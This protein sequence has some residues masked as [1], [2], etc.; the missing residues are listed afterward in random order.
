[1]ELG[2]ALVVMVVLVEVQGEV[3]EQV[4]VRPGE[5]ALLSCG[6][7]WG[8]AG[9]SCTWR[10]P[11]NSTCTF[12][13]DGLT[14]CRAAGNV[15]LGDQATGLCQIRVANPT[16]G[17]NGVWGCS[18]GSVEGSVS[19]GE[20]ALWVAR[21]PEVE[22][23]DSAPGVTVLLVAGEAW[24]TGC[25]AI[26]TRPGGRLVFQ[27]A[28]ED[29]AGLASSDPVVTL[30]VDE[31]GPGILD[32][33]Q[34]L[35]V[36]PE[37]AMD[38]RTLHCTFLQAGPGGEVAA[39]TTSR[40]IAVRALAM[41][42]GTTAEW[43]ASSGSNLTV[44]VEVVAHP[45]PTAAVWA[46]GGVEVEVPTAHEATDRRGH[47]LATPLLQV[48]AYTFQAALTITNVSAADTLHSHSLRIHQGQSPGEGLEHR[49]EVRVDQEPAEGP[50]EKSASLVIVIVIVVI[51]ILVV[52]IV[53][54][55]MVVYAKKNSLW[56]YASSTRPYVNP[57]TVEKKEPLVQHHPYG[58]PSAI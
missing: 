41:A 13:P 54:I 15:L 44:V 31:E 51:I 48:G 26:G 21:E 30:S 9:T 18:V 35:E 14:Q 28:Q 50:G 20:V 22:W 11:D 56:C 16:E 34:S 46:V 19:E 32:I 57:D 7:V 6:T 23:S 17:Q 47:Y 40:R 2:L 37:L 5:D 53:S 39:G 33:E 29:R 25:Q 12:H 3:Q 38:N 8:E 36:E 10:S 42:E 52:V 1:M 45:P 55:M 49:F 58:R 27:W 4:V 43:F 24:T